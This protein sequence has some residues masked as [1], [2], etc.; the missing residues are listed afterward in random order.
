VRSHA[1][2]LKRLHDKVEKLGGKKSPGAAIDKLAEQLLK[3]FK[4][5]AARH[6]QYAHRLRYG[7]NHYYVRHYQTTSR[8]LLDEQ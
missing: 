2:I 7:L 5:P 1:D 6:K 3:D 8:Q 4:A